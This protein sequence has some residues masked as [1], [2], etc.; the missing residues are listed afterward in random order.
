MARTHK[1]L[2][3]KVTSLGDL[4]QAA[5]VAPIAGFFSEWELKCVNLSEAPEAVYSASEGRL[6]CMVR[7]ISG[8]AAPIV[9]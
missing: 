4:M 6:R 1:H 5:N 8:C 7:D 9:K 3:L 2:W